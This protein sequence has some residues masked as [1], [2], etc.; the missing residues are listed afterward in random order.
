MSRWKQEDV[1]DKTLYMREWIK[2]ETGK[3]YREKSL[4]RY[5]KWREDNPEQFHKKQK[6]SNIS[7]RCEALKY[8]S[9]TE[10]P[11]CRCCGETNYDFL[12]IDH[13]NGDGADHRREIGMAQGVLDAEGRVEQNVQVGNFPYWLKKNNWPEG[14]QI[15]CVNCNK[16][17]GTQKY[18]I[19]ELNSGIDMYGCL[20]P[21]ENYKVSLKIESIPLRK[22]PERD[23]WLQSPEGLDYIERQAAQKRGKISKKNTRIEVPCS[24]CGISLERKKAEIIKSQTGTFFCGPICTGLYRSGKIPGEYSAN[25]SLENKPVMLVTQNDHNK[26]E[27]SCEWCKSTF[28]RIPAEIRKNKTGIFFCKKEC[29]TAHR[30]YKKESKN[31]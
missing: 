22:G 30:S 3:E 20:I 28:E 25:L 21:Q 6:E 5:K 26:I 9:Y 13:K 1:S 16:N 17:K 10:I 19:H 12:Q 24:Q 29:F 4:E 15:L 18:C 31:I 8:Y 7:V 23:A 14:F 11:S 2:T 27:L